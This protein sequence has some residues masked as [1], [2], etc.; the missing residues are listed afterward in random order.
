DVSPLTVEGVG[1]LGSTQRISAVVVQLRQAVDPTTG[2]D[3]ANYTLEG[4]A[5]GTFRR[6]PFANPVYN[7]ANRTVTLHCL[8][9]YKL[10]SFRR[11]R[12][13]VNGDGPSGV[14]DH[15]GRLLDG[16]N[17]GVPGGDFVELLRVRQGKTVRYTDHDGDRVTLR[18]AGDVSLDLIQQ[19]DGDVVQAWAVQSR[20]KP[21]LG[22]PFPPGGRA[23][24]SAELRSSPGADGIATM[25]ELVGVRNVT[26]TGIILGPGDEAA[27]KL[28]VERIT[29][30]NQADPFAN[31][32][33]F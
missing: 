27:G 29:P 20:K 10:A 18:C 23:R 17:D 16:N 26:L 24:L 30:G 31:P 4:M 3:H 14:T 7:P 1:F 22:R 11:Y 2:Q 15:E 9:P 12:I 32:L 5:G 19:S 33:S 13:A 28:V 21:G 6:I 8:R 25:L